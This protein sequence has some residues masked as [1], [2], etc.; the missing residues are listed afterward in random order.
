MF[1]TIDVY[2][3]A[4]IL[5]KSEAYRYFGARFYELF[6]SEKCKEIYTRDEFNDMQSAL[7]N[8][9]TIVVD[10][11]KNQKLLKEKNWYI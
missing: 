3:N 4:N 1:E 10:E 8:F 6:T 2:V 11:R 7:V 5:S 9:K